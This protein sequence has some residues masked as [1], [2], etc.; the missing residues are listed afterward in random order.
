MANVPYIPLYIGDW[1]QDTNC[2]SL[3]A[4]AAWLKIIFKM[5]KDNKSGIYKSSTKAL[6]NLWKCSDF[7]VN[8]IIE[9][10]IECNICDLEKLPGAIIFKNRRMLKEKNISEN[11]TKAVQKRY[12][13]STKPLQNAEYENEY[14]NETEIENSKGKEE[15]VKEEKPLEAEIN[16]SFIIPQMCKV[17]YESFPNYTKDRNSDFEGM[18]KILQFMCRQ[19]KGDCLSQ[20]NHLK[21]LNTLQLIADQVNRETFWINK[22]IKSIANHIQEFYNKIKNPVNG[23]KNESNSQ[24]LRERVQAKFEERINQRQQT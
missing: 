4:E 11:R 3:Q 17:W 21:I 23:K 9:E 24:N 8:E 6:Q 7:V 20:D 22:P 1:E 18:G 19:A 2:L 15:S 5:H 12:K 13:T 14:D 10:L 16:E